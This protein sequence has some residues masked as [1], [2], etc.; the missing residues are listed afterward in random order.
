MN[1]TLVF[2]DAGFLSKLS[3]HFGDGGYLRFDLDSFSKNI[4]KRQN[5]FC[6]DIF[7]YTAPPFLPNNPTESE[8]KMKKAYD[9]FKNILVNKNIIFREGR[10]Q[11]LKTKG[12]FEYKQKGVDSLVVMDMM[13]V[14]IDYPNIRNIILIASDSDFVPVINNLKKRG[15]R[16]T[17]CTYYKKGRE[18]RFSKSNEL[19][20]SASKY[21]L[22]S[23]KDFSS[24]LLNLK[25]D[26]K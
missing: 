6:E 4:S 20:K 26:E 15:I 14:P 2:I 12:T 23:K 11:R 16:T 1:K 5:M 3:K 10:C 22:L 24:C 25:G 13:T 9:N 18:S 17:L 7:Y 19:I 8:I 21:S